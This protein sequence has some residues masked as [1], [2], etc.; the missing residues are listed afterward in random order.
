MLENF[1]LESL[2]LDGLSDS[3]KTEVHISYL[4]FVAFKE[5]LGE[6]KLG[7]FILESK[8]PSLLWRSTMASWLGLPW[9]AAKMLESE[10]VLLN[11]MSEMLKL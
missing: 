11:E 7:V 4:A 3:Y 5:N 9:N 10:A 2:G 1:N 8:I 6:K